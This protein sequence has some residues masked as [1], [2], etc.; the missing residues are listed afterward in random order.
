LA[1]RTAASDTFARLVSGINERGG[2]L[3]LVLHILQNLSYSPAAWAEINIISDDVWLDGCP[4]KMLS[5]N[6]F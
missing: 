2:V 6:V 4:P 3:L 5:A 1:A